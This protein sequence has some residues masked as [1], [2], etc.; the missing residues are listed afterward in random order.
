MRVRRLIERIRSRFQ[1]KE[2]APPVQDVHPFRMA[3]HTPEGVP[4]APAVQAETDLPDTL[5]ALLKRKRDGRA[6]MS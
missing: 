2:E 6:P 5:Q 4:E 3:P 1:K